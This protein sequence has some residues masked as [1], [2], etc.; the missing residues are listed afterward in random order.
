MTRAAQSPGTTSSTYDL[1]MRPCPGEPA[2]LDHAGSYCEPL[3]VGTKIAHRTACFYGPSSTGPTPNEQCRR[4]DRACRTQQVNNPTSAYCPPIRRTASPAA[5]TG[6]ESRSS[7]PAAAPHRSGRRFL[8]SSRHNTRR[9][10]RKGTR[11][12][13][14][15]SRE[16]S[17]R[18]ARRTPP[19]LRIGRRP[20][21]WGQSRERCRRSK[22]GCNAASA[23]V[24]GSSGLRCRSALL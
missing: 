13:R 2:S 14:N 1:A 16:A 3:V 11:S 10:A 9:L 17:Q 19:L 12:R 15:A 23:E 7:P 24:S 4:Y 21:L 20:R 22:R 5:P 6:P 18:L 8:C